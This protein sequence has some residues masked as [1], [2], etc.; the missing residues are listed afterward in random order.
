MSGTGDSNKPVAGW[1]GAFSATRPR[2]LVGA[3]VVLALSEVV[4]VVALRQILMTQLHEEI[5]TRIQQEI[6]EFRNISEGDDPETGRAFGS[7]VEALFDFYFSR[8]VADEG[9]V[10]LS[11]VDGGLY[12]DERSGDATYRLET[13]PAVRDRLLSASR[14]ERGALSAPGGD[15][16]YAALPVASRSGEEATFVVANLPAFERAEIDHAVRVG[17]VVAI[18]TLLLASYLVWVIA[19]RIL[20]PLEELAN[21]AG[22]VT[23]SE[24][25]RRI[26]VRGPDEVSQ[27][28]ANFNAMLDRLEEAFAIQRR[29]AD[30]AGHELRT[31]LTIVRG[32]LE[33]MGDDA[34]ERRETVALVID[35]IERMERM[36]SDL[37][38]LAQAGQ[39]AFLNAE[40]MD[41]EELTSD[42]LTKASALAPR[43]WSL[44]QESSGAILA[45]RQRLTQALL[46]LAQ[47]AVH[48]TTESDGIEIGSMLGRG[49]ALFWVTDTGAGIPFEDQERIFERFDRGSDRRSER[50]GAGLGLSIV[51]AIAEAH[52]GSVSVRSQPGEGASFTI[53]VPIRD[54]RSKRDRPTGVAVEGLQD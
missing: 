51:R 53:E 19:G 32:H 35:E 18:L 48:H 33:L 26:P 28:A 30:D 6:D 37:L 9:E 44:N 4:S 46:Q 15:I 29:F 5:D 52:G 22:G 42:V 2:I 36:V 8:E 11:F 17:I 43:R 47:N 40:R 24:L 1:R 13:V 12:R 16:R 27:L 21:T 31:P 50:V 23:H 41:I 45:D 7:D 38:V 25:T 20:S 34:E 49:A 3:I 10:L 14:L 39:P 54:S